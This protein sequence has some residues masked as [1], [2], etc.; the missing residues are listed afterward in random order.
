MAG[1]FKHLT[2]CSSNLGDRLRLGMGKLQQAI[3][4][5]SAT[6]NGKVAHFD[7]SKFNLKQNK[8]YL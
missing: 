7:V 5:T 2:N 1:K 6:V 3:G 8:K 4:E